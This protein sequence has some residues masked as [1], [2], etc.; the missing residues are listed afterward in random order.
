MNLR[1]G[2]GSEWCGFDL[3]EELFERC[4][5][6]FLDLRTK[7]GKIQRGRLPLEFFEFSDPLGSQ[8]VRASRQNLAKLDKGRSED[9]KN[10][11]YTLG[12]FKVCDVI[13]VLQPMILPVY[14]VTVSRPMCLNRSPKP[15]MLKTRMIS[16]SRF[17]SAIVD[18]IAM[19]QLS[20]S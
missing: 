10:P 14:S 1:Q 20:F 16:P 2:S 11:A 5:Q 3:C 13:Y 9:F 7:L 18:W 8:Q 6:I 15:A 19:I 4:S 12:M 17:R